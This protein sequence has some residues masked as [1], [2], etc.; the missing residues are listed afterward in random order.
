[1]SG[2]DHLKSLNYMNNHMTLIAIGAVLLE[3]FF[4]LPILVSLYLVMRKGR[5]IKGKW[6]FILL[7]PVMASTL[8]S[9]AAI[10][11]ALPIAFISIYI[12]P[13]FVQAFGYK[14]YWLPLAEFFS[15]YSPLSYFVIVVSVW[16]VIG[17]WLTV[18]L[19]PR[20]PKLFEALIH[21]P[22]SK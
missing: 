20:W 22:I 21:K 2:F 1:M 6:L 12:V 3:L 17:T 9:L 7:G 4:W 16:I 10:A 18:Y 11:I 13:A 5:G 14:P 15:R 19:W 8:L